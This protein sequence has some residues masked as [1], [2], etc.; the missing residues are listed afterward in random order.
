LV[1]N[2]Y[3]HYDRETDF[4]EIAES[5]Q[6]KFQMQGE[7]ITPWFKNAWSQMK[8]GFQSWSQKWQNYLKR[9]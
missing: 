6:V 3:Q 4:D 7:L 9:L 1:Q 2:V 8:L 5:T